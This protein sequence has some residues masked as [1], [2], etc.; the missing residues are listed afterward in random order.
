MLEAAGF[1]GVRVIARTGFRTSKFTSG[2]T[3]VATKPV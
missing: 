2:L 1:C 3:F